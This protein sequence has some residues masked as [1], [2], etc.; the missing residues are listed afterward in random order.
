MHDLRPCVFRQQGERLRDKLVQ[1]FG[2]LRTA[3]HQQAHRTEAAEK[4][5]RRGRRGGNFRAYRVAGN[6]VPAFF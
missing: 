1:G 2:A 3:E 5:L 6:D 4:T